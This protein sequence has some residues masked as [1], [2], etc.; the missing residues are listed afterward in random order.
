MKH[1]IRVLSVTF[2]LTL[3]CNQILLAQPYKNLVEIT[4]QFSIRSFYWGEYD[5]NSKQLLEETGYL[6]SGGLASKIKFSSNF[7]LFIRIDAYFYGGLVDYN[8]F[9]MLQGG[10]TQPYKSKT[11]Y[12]GLETALNIGYDF[13]VVDNFAIA[14]EFGVQYEYWNRDIDNGGQYGYDEVYNAFLL[15][16]GCSFIVPFSNSSKIFLNALGEYPIFITES[17]NLASR[18]QGGPPDINLEPQPNIGFSAELGAA[19]YGSFISFYADYILFS[20]SPFDKGFHQPMSDRTVVGIKLG[21][22][23]SIN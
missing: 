12:Y 19:I 18:G 7:D 20:K 1:L 23:F 16:F 11:G 22:T 14:P 13:F 6:Y 3:A 10:G 8:G 15:D 9:L 17:V 4:P 2:L 21:Y 5:N